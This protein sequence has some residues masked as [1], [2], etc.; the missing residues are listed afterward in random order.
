MKMKEV[1]MGYQMLQTKRE[2]SKESIEKN[3]AQ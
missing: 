1:M 2:R 3:E